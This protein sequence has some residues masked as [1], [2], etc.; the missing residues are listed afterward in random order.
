[1]ASLADYIREQL[2]AGYTLNQIKDYLF[3]Y[4]YGPEAVDE[5]VKQV[6]QPE[7]KHV[8]HLS[9]TTVGVVVA[10][11]FTILLASGTAF[12]LLMPK[13]EETLM[14][15]DNEI[16][17]EN[18]E[19]GSSVDFIVELSNL[20]AAKRFDI[21]VTNRIMDYDAN[22]IKESTETV[23]V[24][25]RSTQKKS[26]SLE[27][28]D[29]GNYFLQTIAEYDGKKATASSTFKVYEKTAEPTCFDNILNQGES[30]VDCGGPC[31]ACANCFDGI[32]NQ[33]EEDVDCG[34][35]CQACPSCTDGTRN[36]GEEG[37]D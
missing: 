4:G 7:V 25:T 24:E 8:I 1:M 26:M 30:D 14:D 18:V 36:Q 32:K 34:G 29:P 16:I 5:A 9:R 3:K 35:S 10:I 19:L 15:V 31:S 21:L 22:V 27:G 13:A 20:G 37:V 28:V 6:Y 17:N 33:G 2:K 12:F 23:A 11:I